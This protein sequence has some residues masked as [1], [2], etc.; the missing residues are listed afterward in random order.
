MN[1]NISRVP[2]P[3]NEPPWNAEIIR[4]PVLAEF[5]VTDIPLLSVPVCMNAGEAGTITAAL[6][7]TFRS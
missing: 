4:C 7:S 1:C 5:G 6:K 2:A 3:L